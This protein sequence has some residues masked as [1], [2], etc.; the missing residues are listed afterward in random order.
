M[1]SYT[2]QYVDKDDGL[3]YEA[4][5]LAPTLQDAVTQF[6]A[7]THHQHWLRGVSVDGMPHDCGPPS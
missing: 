1:N 7:E 2:V 6:E 4:Q 3:E 5:V